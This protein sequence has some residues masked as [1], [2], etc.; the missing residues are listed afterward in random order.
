MTT[1][2]DYT[3]QAGFSGTKEN[4]LGIVLDVYVGDTPLDL[5]GQTIVFRA[6]DGGGSEVLR[7]QSPADVTIQAGQETAVLCGVLVPFTVAESRL[8]AAA[9]QPL[10]YAIERRSGSTQRP[11]VQGNLFVEGSANDD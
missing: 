5:T 6:L 11:I 8:V 3:I 1:T 7:K 10:T 2:Q 9:V 4:D